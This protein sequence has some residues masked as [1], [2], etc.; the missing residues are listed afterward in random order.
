MQKNICALS[1]F[2]KKKYYACNS[3]AHKIM[4]QVQVAIRRLRQGSMLVFS[5]YAETAC[6]AV[7]KLFL[8]I[9]IL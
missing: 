1:R 7:Q 4:F 5:L 3:S 9:S 6:S 8:K 2:L